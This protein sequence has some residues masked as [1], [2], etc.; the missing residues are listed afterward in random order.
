MTDQFPITP[1]FPDFRALCAE[2]VDKLDELNCNFNIPSQS[3]LIERANDA[4]ATPP[5][6]PPKTKPNLTPILASILLGRHEPLEWHHA[7]F[8]SEYFGYP[9]KDELRNI[10]LTGVYSTPPP[11]P[12][13]DEELLRKY[14]VAKRDFCYEG[15]IDDWPKRAE[16]AA[17]IYGLR[18][19]LERWGK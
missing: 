5:P 19:V 10:A 14:G 7:A 8:L 15:P 2:L 16:R 6:E 9:S 4:L 1:D 18:A 17:T 3:A 13:T 12:P 11:E